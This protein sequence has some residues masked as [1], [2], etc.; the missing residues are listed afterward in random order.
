[1]ARVRLLKP[2][3]FTND[4]LAEVPPLGRL[5]F[6]GLWTICDREGRLEDRPKRIKAEILPFDN[7]NVDRLLEELASLGFIER[8]ES[9]GQRLIQVVSFTRHQSPHPKEPASKLPAMGQPV[10]SHL[11]D[12]DSPLSSPAVNSNHY[13]PSDSS[14][15]VSVTD[16]DDGTPSDELSPAV[17]EIRDLILSKLPPMNARDPLTW[18]EAEQFAT[19]FAGQHREVSAA[20]AECRRTPAADGGGL[21]FPQKL[22]R[23]M[24]DNRP[25]KKGPYYGEEGIFAGLPD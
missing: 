10:T 16:G 12:S 15:P 25:K 19:D 3:F 2:G 9:G 11:P 20:I 14:D 6:A 8:Y 13:I 17:R 21:P 7:A 18:D 23:F 22:R 4:L 24:P 5:L 1:M